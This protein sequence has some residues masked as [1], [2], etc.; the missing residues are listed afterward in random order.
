MGFQI[1]GHEYAAAISAGL[2]ETQSSL[3]C[4]NHNPVIER[5]VER[6]Q[7]KRLDERQDEWLASSCGK[8]LQFS[9]TQLQ[10]RTAS[11]PQLGQ[12]SNC[13]CAVYM[14]EYCGGASI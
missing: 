8:I 14:V 6:S 11:H 4:P 10:N 2:D 7:M 13:C 12:C 1:C 3:V 9:Y 5:Q